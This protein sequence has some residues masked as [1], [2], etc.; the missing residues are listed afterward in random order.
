MALLILIVV[1]GTSI[2]VAIDASHL[3]VKR[4]T[5][6]GGLFDMGAAA[7]FFSVLL[8]WI[9]GFPAYLITRPRYVTAKSQGTEGV[10]TVSPS[11]APRAGWYPD[12]DDPA[13]R[14]WW[15]GATWGPNE[16]NK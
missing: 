3:G 11:S 16:P 8:L 13:M 5:L 7:W 2:W 14:R 15:N 12:P 6:G 4:G 1:A 9:I 10:L